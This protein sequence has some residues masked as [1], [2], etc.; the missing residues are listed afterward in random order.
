M[1]KIILGAIPFI[2]MFLII[3]FISKAKP[4]QHLREHSITIQNGLLTLPVHNDSDVFNIKGNWHFT[5]NQFYCFN[6]S[7]QPQYAPLPG[8]L[9]DSPLHSA[10]GYASYGLHIAGLDPEKIY[11]LRTGYIL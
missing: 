2:C 11:A 1:K 4:T 3:T 8:K 7:A 9:S 5:P 10:Y 6:N